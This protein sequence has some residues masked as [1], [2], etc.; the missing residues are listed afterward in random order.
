MSGARRHV[1]EDDRD[2]ASRRPRRPSRGRVMQPML[3]TPLKIRDITLRNR[4]VV[5]PMLTYSADN[6]HVNDWHLAHLAGLAAGGAGLV[7]M[8]STKV[9]PAGCSTPRDTGLWKDEFVAPLKRITTLIRRNGAVSGIQ[10]GHSGRDRKSVCR[11]R[12]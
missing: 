12:V 4:I 7:F 11:E 5:S 2:R 8:E 3:F 10:L 1:E 9:D 6:G